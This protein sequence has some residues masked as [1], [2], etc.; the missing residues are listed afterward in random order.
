[1]KLK[2]QI[3]ITILSALALGAA[4]YLISIT[5]AWSLLGGLSGTF[6]STLIGAV[7]GAA[8]GGLISFV[9][10]ERAADRTEGLERAREHDRELALAQTAMVKIIKILSALN[11]IRSH[12]HESLELA[13][14]HGAWH[15]KK[16]AFVKS[17]GN[18][19]AVIE[20]SADELRTIRR[21]GDDE[22]TN[23]VMDLDTIYNDLAALMER[24][25]ADR[26]RLFSEFGATV[27]GEIATTTLDEKQSL[28]FM[29]RA[30]ELES[31]IVAIIA[32]VQG[33]FD[34]AN[35]ALARLA[36]AGQAKFGS[37]FGSYTARY[38]DKLEIP[39]LGKSGVAGAPAASPFSRTISALGSRLE[40]FRL[41]AREW[42]GALISGHAR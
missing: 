11:L 12:V 25:S 19:L 34:Q 42:I 23:G 29:P 28:L 1:M 37:K 27:T 14:N 17:I 20:I 32:R 4:L 24:Y 9:L 35:M 30:A 36:R 7:V 16:M 38:P 21:L 10:Q 31:L 39:D 5:T 26:S 18:K 41:K 33:D 2:S 3:I 15:Q 13:N 8:M 22:L 6:W 40:G